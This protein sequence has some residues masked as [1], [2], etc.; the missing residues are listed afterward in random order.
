MK[1]LFIGINYFDTECELKGC[2][3]D[4]NTISQLY[5]KLYGL[6]N[7][8]I[9]TDDQ[10]NPNK[11]PTKTNIL[12]GIDWLVSNNKLGEQ[13]FFHYSGHRSYI[14]D[15]SGDESDGKDE[16][17]IPCDYNINGYIIDDDLH[18]KL[19]NKIESAYLFAVMDNCHSGTVLD[20]NYSCKADGSVRKITSN[21]TPYPSLNVVLLSGCADNQTSAD[22]VEKI[23]NKSV[24]CG[25]LSWALYY[26]LGMNS[27]V[28]YRDLITGVRDLLAKSKY[29]QIPQISFNAFPTLNER[30]IRG[31]RK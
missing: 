19:V 20:L 28:T 10:S 3:N 12:S 15:V 26:T 31:D 1:G 6:T 25:A 18:A 9:L 2:I 5:K 27:E 11:L 14:I 29:E 17:I 22:T 13:L 23:N 4:I 8:L 30:V 21:Y 24:S 7:I 16:C